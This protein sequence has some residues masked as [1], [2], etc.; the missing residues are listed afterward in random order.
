MK[1]T[2]ADSVFFLAM[3]NVRDSCH[4]KAVALSDTLAGRIVTTQ[5]V[6]VEVGDAFSKP[7]DRDRFLELLQLIE[8]DKR[9]EVVLASDAYFKS[10]TELLL[11]VLTSFGHL[12][13]ASASS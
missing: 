1:T 8:E 12:P 13:I 6:L 5:W 2:F 9:F 10:A 3:M 7:Q 4:R 11:I